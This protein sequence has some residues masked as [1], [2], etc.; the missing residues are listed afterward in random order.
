MSFQALFNTM[1]A[2]IAWQNQHSH[3]NEQESTIQSGSET[4]MTTTD[5]ELE[6]HRFK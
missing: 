5:N 4:E 3:Q 6:P 1:I 2:M